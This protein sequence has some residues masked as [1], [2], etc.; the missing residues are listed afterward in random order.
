MSKILENTSKKRAFTISEAAEYACV[1]RGTLTGWITKGA[2]PYEDLPG[3]GNGS[4]K[5]R[6]IRKND[7]DKF[8]DTHYQGTNDNSFR[9][10]S[11]KLVLL[12]KDT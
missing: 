6:L 2:L 3:R 11:N 4:H 7:L 8:L 10:S 1:S 12:P 5:F 9:N